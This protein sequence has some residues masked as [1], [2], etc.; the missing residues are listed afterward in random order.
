MDLGFARQPRKSGHDVR[1]RVV[2]VKAMR[3]P[4]QLGF[5]LIELV[6]V[7]VLVGVLSVFVAPRLVGTSTVNARGLHD[8][9]LAYLR[10]A[11]K[12]A[13]AQRRTVCV[14]FTTNSMTLSMAS[15]PGVKNCVSATGLAGPKGDSPP[16]VTARSS[17]VAF[18]TVP[19]NFNFDGLGQ[20]VSA[21]T[22]IAFT[23]QSSLPAFSVNGLTG[24]T[25]TVEIGTGYVHD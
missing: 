4:R 17:D 25:I 5:T 12:T 21:S 15:D 20:P 8:E 10:F 19:T 7:I 1:R 9:T 23:A 11:Q 14:A 18:A 13:I 24:Q 2:H 22:G 16:K 3:P 6:M